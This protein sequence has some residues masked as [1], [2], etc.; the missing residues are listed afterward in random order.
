MTNK[1]ANAGIIYQGPSLIDGAPIVVIAT[2]SNR[3]TKTGAMVQTYILRADIDP[4]DANKS[5][6]DYSI[7]GDC[8][9]RGT[10]TQEMN[11]KLATGRACYVVIGQGPLIVF[12]AFKRGVYPDMQGHN[13]TA[14]LGRGRMIRLG[15]YGDP[16]A[17]PSYIWES[18]L[19]D[20]AGHTAYSHQSGV[21]GAQFDPAIMMQSA[22]NEGQARAAW[23]SGARTFRIV[24]DASE[25]VAGKEIH[26]PAQTKSIECQA[27]GLC[28][29]ASKAKSIAVVKHGNG[30]KYIAA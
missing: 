26:C 16:A 28:M 7:C 29:G 10:P 22:D 4:R 6:A 5:G 14:E 3:N 15:A 25:I 17:C 27:C 2:Y 24:S 18:L 21:T 30:A 12:K 11:K 9:H 13:K 20:S 23:D 19:R 1:Q 8:P